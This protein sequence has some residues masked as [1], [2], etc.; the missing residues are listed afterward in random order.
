MIQAETYLDVADNSGAKTV[1]CFRVLGGATRKYAGIGD[2]V[3]C[4]V[5][6]ADP[7]GAV[8]KGEKVLGVVVR[9]RKPLLRSDGT[10]VVFD[11]NAVVLV[12]KEKNPRGTR[13]FGPVARE[14][15]ARGY[16]RI[17]SL[18]IEVV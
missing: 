4:S 16:T 9:T 8:K 11:H 5:K 1:M 13:I 6:T 10:S 3:I 7:N 15:R 12:D 2:E 18:A 17:V 14:L